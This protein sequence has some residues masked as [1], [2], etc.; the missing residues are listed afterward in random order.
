MKQYPW[1]FKLRRNGID[2]YQTEK[3]LGTDS[4]FYYFK[5]GWIDQ[6]MRD[7]LKKVDTKPISFYRFWH[8]CPHAQLNLYYICFFW[9]TPW[10]KPPE[11]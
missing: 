3:Y 9:S 6:R 8:D 7:A 10:T 4:Y 11:E 2:F 1:K 5:W